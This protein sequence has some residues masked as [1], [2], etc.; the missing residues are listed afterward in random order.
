[1]TIGLNILILTSSIVFLLG[2]VGVGLNKRNLLIQVMSGVL[3]VVGENL[4]FIFVPI[5]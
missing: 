5:R 3:M 1:M 4:N 2:L